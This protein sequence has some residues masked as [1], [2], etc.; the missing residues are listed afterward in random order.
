MRMRLDPLAA[1]NIFPSFLHDVHGIIIP[2][3]LG[4]F[5]TNNVQI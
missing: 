1:T 2:Y 5:D 4:S 3:S